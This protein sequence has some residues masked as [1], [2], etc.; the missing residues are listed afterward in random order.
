MVKP[1]IGL[2]PPASDSRSPDPDGA[3]SRTGG[4]GIERHTKRFLLNTAKQ[5]GIGDPGSCEIILSLLSACGDIRSAL[6]R[7]LGFCSNPAA[8]FSA[9]VTL[10]A[11]SPSPTTAADLAYDAEVSRS[12]IAAVIKGLEKRGLVARA[13]GGKE[14]NP[15]VQLTAAGHDVAAAIVQHFLRIANSVAGGLGGEGRGVGVEAFRELERR[16]ASLG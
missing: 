4:V 16:A 15:T 7:E 5:S 10:Y 2:A 13:R 12:S 6:A 3:A 11:L 1:H 14:R 9:L 8:R